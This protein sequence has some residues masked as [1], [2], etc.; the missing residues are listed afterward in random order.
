MG[1]RSAH[2]RALLAVAS[3]VPAFAA[4]ATAHAN[5]DDVPVVL[6]RAD[7]LFTDVVEGPAW[8][9]HARGSADLG[10]YPAGGRYHRWHGRLTGDV[11]IV[12]FAPDALWRM[13]LSMQTVADDRNDISFR[14]VRLY[15]DANALVEHRSGPGALWYG[16]RH[17]CSHG[18][19]SAVD[20]RVLIRSGPEVG[21]QF[22]VDAGRVVL[23]GRGFAHT[24]LIGQNDDDA[25]KPRALAAGVAQARLPMGWAS[26]LL[27]AGLGAA[28][29]GTWPDWTYLLWEEW[30]GPWRVL[31]L[32]AAATGVLLHG[33]AL[34]FRVLLH[35]QRILD[36]GFG[37]TGSPTSLLALELGF[38]W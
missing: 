35:F 10:F 37:A 7:T 36:S 3:A 2:A 5:Q 21:Y 17:R 24:T 34:D 27:S 38:A 29:V 32:P 13:G 12:R 4:P 11:A 25:F 28:L 20:G 14:L 1:V 30:R 26:W 31:P 16:Y 18:A 33:R 15:Y 9:P 6:E 22:D 23:T 8:L 19:D